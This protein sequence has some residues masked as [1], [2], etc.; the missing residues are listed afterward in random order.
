MIIEWSLVNPLRFK[1]G[2]T[3]NLSVLAY[4]EQRTGPPQLP[5]GNENSSGCHV[6]VDPLAC[7]IQDLG[8]K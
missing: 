8:H 6:D 1:G 4:T 3:I 2:D 7:T 5:C